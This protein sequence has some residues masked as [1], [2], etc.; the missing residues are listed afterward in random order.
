MGVLV[1]RESD[2][3]AADPL[4][5]TGPNSRSGQQLRRHNSARQC[6]EDKA[7]PPGPKTTRRLQSWTIVGRA[8][9][10]DIL[11]LEAQPSKH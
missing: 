6:P 7:F 4:A 10:R 9:V 1:L 3:Q 2:I 5:G 8:A 11:G